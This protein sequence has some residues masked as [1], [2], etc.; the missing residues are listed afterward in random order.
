VTF[1]AAAWKKKTMLNKESSP[2]QAQSTQVRHEQ[3]PHKPI[4][5]NKQDDLI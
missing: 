3:K 4:P 5:K 1:G 2:S